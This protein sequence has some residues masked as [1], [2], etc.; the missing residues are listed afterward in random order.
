MCVIN[1]TVYFEFTVRAIFIQSMSSANYLRLQTV[2]RDIFSFEKIGVGTEFRISHHPFEAGNSL[3]MIWRTTV[4]YSYYERHSMIPYLVCDPL[5]SALEDCGRWG[6]CT[7]SPKRLDKNH[8]TVE[9][10]SKTQLRHRHTSSYSHWIF[11]RNAWM[12]RDEHFML[13]FFG[14][15]WNEDMAAEKKWLTSAPNKD[16]DEG[17]NWISGIYSFRVAAR[18]KKRKNKQIKFLCDSRIGDDFFFSLR[19]LFRFEPKPRNCI[20][21]VCLRRRHE[22]TDKER[23][24]KQSTNNVHVW[25]LHVCRSPA[26]AAHISFHLRRMPRW[27]CR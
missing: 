4:S 5:H 25:R 3:V 2:E 1:V 19:L 13:D 11:K 20:G 14:F 21:T 26:V 24:R 18:P 7:Q 23:N 6:Q 27:R 17:H 12:H 8:L 22:C 15:A 9:T 10:L 16:S